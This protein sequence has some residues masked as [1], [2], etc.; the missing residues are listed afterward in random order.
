[1]LQEEATQVDHVKYGNK[2]ATDRK[3]L[4]PDRNNNNV[5]DPPQVKAE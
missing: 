1:M 3:A 5:G 2:A 4:R